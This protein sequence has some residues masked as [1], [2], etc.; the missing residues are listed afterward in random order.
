MLGIGC[1]VP[2]SFSD[3]ELY[4]V[5]LKTLVVAHF[6]LCNFTFNTHTQEI[7]ITSHTIKKILLY[8][9]YTFFIKNCV[10]MC[11]SV[12][13]VYVHM[14]VE[15]ACVHVCVCVC[16]CAHMPCVCVYARAC[17]ATGGQVSSSINPCL[18]PLRHRKWRLPFSARLAASKPQDSFLSSSRAQVLELHAAMPGF[19]LGCLRFEQKELLLN[20]LSFSQSMDRF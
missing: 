16:A 11:A 18:S 13:V 8:V 4:L 15:C 6:A 9:M 17:E 1:K 19:S 20:E 3:V 7:K 2:N 14:C 12:L 5:E 10:F